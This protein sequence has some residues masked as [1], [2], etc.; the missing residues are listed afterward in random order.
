M[1]M[2]T[3]VPG[4][5]GRFQSVVSLTGWDLLPEHSLLQCLGLSQLKQAPF[6]GG[7]LQGVLLG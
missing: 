7:G 3:V 6:P 4:Q 5:G 2:I 1:Q